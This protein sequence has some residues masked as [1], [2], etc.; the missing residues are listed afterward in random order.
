[1][2]IYSYTLSI[3]VL[4]WAVQ[5]RLFFMSIS[6]LESSPEDATAFLSSIAGGPVAIMRLLALLG[7]APSS[8]HRSCQSAGE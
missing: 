6:F 8:D 1:M 4:A 7:G 3:M 2:T 5:K